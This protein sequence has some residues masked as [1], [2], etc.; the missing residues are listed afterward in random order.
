MSQPKAKSNKLKIFGIIIGFFFVL[1]IFLI[2]QIVSKMPS[3]SQISRALKNVSSEDHSRPNPASSA[4]ALSSSSQNSTTN[5]PVSA[6]TEKKKK[7]Q[8][9]MKKL[10]S[11]IEEN[12]K[13]IRVCEQLGQTRVNLK[14]PDTSFEMEALFSED[15]DD[16][17]FEAARIPLRAML[18]DPPVAELMREV[19]NISE[20]VEGKSEADR[21]DFF[22]KIGFYARVA[23]AASSLYSQKSQ[24]ESLGDHAQHLSVLVKLAA[25]RPEFRNNSRILDFCKRIETTSIN[26]TRDDM[27][28]ERQELLALLKENHISAKDMDFDPN[29]WTK[30]KVNSDQH[31]F[32]FSLSDKEKTK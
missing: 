19:Q 1:G 3:R 24:L 25:L 14:S 22:S 8:E 7:D 30:F 15:R 27:I 5:T 12:P 26:F 18:Q 28:A 32:S 20:S 29:H 2:Y 23:R 9:M 11:I 4:I 17:F 13:D 31:G 6:S 10:I 21:E 16:S